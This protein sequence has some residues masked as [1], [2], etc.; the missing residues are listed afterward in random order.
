MP[1]SEDAIYLTTKMQAMAIREFGG[2]DVLQPV[3]RDLPQPSPHEV[4]IKLAAAGVNRPDLLQ[5]AGHY[6]VPANASDLPGLEASGV[7]VKMGEGIG[8]EG[9][10]HNTDLNPFN[11]R[12]GD[13]VV[14]LCNGG[15]YAEYCTVPIGQVLPH[16]PQLSMIEAAALA[17]TIFTVWY[18]VLCAVGCARA[19]IS[20]FT[21]RHR[22]LAPPPFKSPKPWG[23]GYLPPLAPVKNWIYAENWAAIG[24]LTATAKISSK[25]AANTPIIK[26]LT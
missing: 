15:A 25:F 1:D 24:S 9:I 2:P 22:A 16:P 3:E 10:A 6:P 7:I 5:R 26:A 17:E 13:R 21:A 11:L 23:R 18:N 19:R 14:A 12:L 4:L 8:G 20:S